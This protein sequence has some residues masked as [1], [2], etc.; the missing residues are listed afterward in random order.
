[1]TY[2]TQQDLIKSF[3]EA[4]LIIMTDRDNLGVINEDVLNNAID[5]AAAE[6]D[7]YISVRYSLPLN[8]T[9]SVLT[10]HA[11]NITR[12]R[13]YDNRSRDEVTERY[14]QAISFLDKISKGTVSLGVT[15]SQESEVSHKVTA[16]Q[17]VSKLNWD[18]F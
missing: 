16:K 10:L 14:K 13:L 3:D 6:I 12:Y 9:P 11:C 2:C 15:S 7:S 8:S 4:E 5:N 18:G 17:G 1:M